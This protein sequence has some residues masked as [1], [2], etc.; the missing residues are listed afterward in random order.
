M[1]RADGDLDAVVVTYLTDP[2]VHRM[3][4]HAAVDHHLTVTEATS[5]MG[6]L[7]YRTPMRAVGGLVSPRFGARLPADRREALREELGLRGDRPIVLVVTGSLGLGEVPDAVRQIAATGCAQVV[8]LCGRNTRLR[9][10]FS[11]D[12]EGVIALG[13]RDDVPELMA[14][15]DVLV[16]NAGGLTLTEAL[17]A[18]LPAITFRPIPGHGTANAAT[19]LDAGLAPWPKDST[20]LVEAVR[21]FTALRHDPERWFVT[22]TPP[23]WLR[24]CFTPARPGRPSAPREP[25]IGSGTVMDWS[26]C[27]R[28][29]RRRPSG[30]RPPCNTM[31]PGP[32]TGALRW[33]R[34][35]SWSCSPGRAGCWASGLRCSAWH[36]TCAR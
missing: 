1:L 36:C 20:E 26:C 33:T 8:V 14:V 30:W 23:S 29:R 21:G 32:P 34:G 27:C 10:Q 35:W 24:G 28:W 9:A 16:H 18:G 13:W 15:A 11:P 4:V 7:A 2:A 12:D 25:G 3:W 5:R 19:L 17:T 31:A 6:R 22:R